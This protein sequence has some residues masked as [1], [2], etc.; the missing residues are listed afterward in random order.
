M[1]LDQYLYEAWT[2]ENKETHLA[3]LVYWRKA[4]QIQEWFNKRCVQKHGREMEN[5]EDFEVTKE[6]LEDLLKDLEAVNNDHSLAG[7]LLPTASGFFYGSTE[8]DEWYF[9]DIERSI[10]DIKGVLDVHEDG[11]KYLYHPW[12]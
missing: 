1:G 8:Y 4:N 2:D 10:R 7:K 9:E 6:D 11:M 12:W 5:C 3:E